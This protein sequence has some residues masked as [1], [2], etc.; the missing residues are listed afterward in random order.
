M[1]A[2][3][4]MVPVR[5]GILALDNATF[6][7]RAPI[8]L[9]STP[10]RWGAGHPPRPPLPHVRLWVHGLMAVLYV[11]NNRNL[12]NLIVSFRQNPPLRVRGS[13][14]CLDSASRV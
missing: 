13:C 12:L 5:S 8:R 4:E 14:L 10:V 7:N 1:G 6:P 11:V 2:A 9:A 3:A